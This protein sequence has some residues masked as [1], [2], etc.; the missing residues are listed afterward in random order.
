MTKKTCVYTSY[1]SFYIQLSR[2]Y[3]RPESALKPRSYSYIHGS[4]LRNKNQSKREITKKVYVYDSASFL[5]Q[6]ESKNC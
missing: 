3:L 6:R 2:E 5:G 4:M 1:A